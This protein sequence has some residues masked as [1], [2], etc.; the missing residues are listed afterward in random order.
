MF[1]GL[2]LHY[3]EKAFTA[4]ALNFF[5]A[6]RHLHEPSAFRRYLAPLWNTEWMIYAKRPFAGPA[7]VLDYVAMLPRTR[8]YWPHCMRRSAS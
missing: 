2:F 8:P 5:S 4:G 6:Y 1:R 3:L 7:Q